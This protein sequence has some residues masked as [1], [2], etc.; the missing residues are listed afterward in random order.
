MYLQKEDKAEHW[1]LLSHSQIETG[2]HQRYVAEKKKKKKK[3]R[4]KE[5]EERDSKRE[6]EHKKN[7]K[8]ECKLE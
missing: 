2:V 5:T 4:K 3:K 6:V 7:K 1:K 8:L